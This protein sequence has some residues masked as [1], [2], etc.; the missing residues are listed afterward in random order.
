MHITHIAYTFITVAHTR[1]Q[2]QY[3]HKFSHF[4]SK[5]SITNAHEMHFKLQILNLSRIGQVIKTH[6]ISNDSH[7]FNQGHTT[8]LTSY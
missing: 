7:A 6:N 4:K 8:T 1:T 5:S 3:I 2:A